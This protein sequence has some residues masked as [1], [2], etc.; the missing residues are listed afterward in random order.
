MA[1]IRP[2]QGSS[3]PLHSKHELHPSEGTAEKI[4]QFLSRMV[5]A[6]TLFSMLAGVVGT[7]LWGV[8]FGLLAGGLGGLLTLRLVSHQRQSTMPSPTN[9]SFGTFNFPFQNTQKLRLAVEIDFGDVD[10]CQV[11]L[12]SIQHASYTYCYRRGNL[13]QYAFQRNGYLIKLQTPKGSAC[14]YTDHLGGVASSDDVSNV[15]LGE[16]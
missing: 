4:R 12:E 14:Y 7:V 11:K 5:G 10:F 13:V 15:T 1:G 6:G 8:R 16:I 9:P 3:E 2:I